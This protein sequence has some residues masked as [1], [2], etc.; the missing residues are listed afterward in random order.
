MERSLTSP[1]AAPDSIVFDLDGTLWNTC[2]VCAVAWNHVLERHGIAFREITA[3]DVESVAGKPH[4]A[5]IREVFAGL[6]ERDIQLLIA[7]TAREDIRFIR[8]HGGELYDGVAEGLGR[9]A[10]RVPL[11]IVSNCQAGYIELFV[12]TMGFGALFRDIECW[13]NTG[14]PKDENLRALIARNRLGRPVFVGD[15]EGDRQAAE[16]C[17]IPFVHVTYGYFDL[18]GDHA[19]FDSFEALA[20]HFLETV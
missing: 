8:E 19:R 6:S 12:E 10:E 9:L 11:F 15:A 3:R 13:G 20:R 2:P 18:A 5:C 1:S 7:E 14:R 4:E 17:G 16:A